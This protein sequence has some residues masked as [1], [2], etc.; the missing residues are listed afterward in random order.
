MR[1]IDDAVLAR[2]EGLPFDVKDGFFQ[3][4]PDTGKVVVEYALPYAVYYSSVGDDD[5]ATRRLSAR[6][7][8]ESVFF[9]VTYVGLDRNQTKW[10]G[11]LLW[12]RLRRWRPV[13]D[14]LVCEVIQRQESQRIRRDD[15][16]VRPDGSPLF[17]GVD[18]YAVG[19]R[20]PA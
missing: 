5:E 19:V 8:R 6:T 16:A 20:L 7:P 2:F 11:E 9:S 18:N 4:V 13:I 14:G 12:S 17:Y 1:I 10:A 15:T 3:A